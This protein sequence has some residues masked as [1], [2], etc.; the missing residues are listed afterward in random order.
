LKLAEYVIL[1]FEVIVLGSRECTMKKRSILGINEEV[2]VEMVGD[3]GRRRG[4][5]HGRKEVSC[6]EVTVSAG[7]YTLLVIPQHD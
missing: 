5:R 2:K 1:L 4:G 3:N 7:L 6:Q